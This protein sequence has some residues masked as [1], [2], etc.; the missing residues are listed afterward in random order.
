MLTLVPKNKVYNATDFMDDV[1]KQ[2][3]RLV[4]YPIHSYWLD[5]GQPNDFEKA[6]KDI[7]HINWD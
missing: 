4:H 5:I 6:Q 1:I 7:A 2:N 3:K